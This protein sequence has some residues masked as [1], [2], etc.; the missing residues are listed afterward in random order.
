MAVR[1]AATAAAAIVAAGMMDARAATILPT[2]TPG[3]PT[4]CAGKMTQT[5]TDPANCGACG[6]DC[7][8]AACVGALCRS[9]L[10]VADKDITSIAVD[11][12]D[13]LWT[14][15]KGVFNAPAST[16]SPVTGVVT[17]SKAFALVR[18]GSSL[19]WRQADGSV[20]T[21]TSGATPKNLV[22]ATAPGTTNEA[23]GL[24]VD[25]G[26]VYWAQNDTIW[27][28]PATGGAPSMFLTQT[29]TV[30][31]GSGGG[32]VV[33]VFPMRS[34]VVEAG[35][36]DWLQDYVRRFSLVTATAGNKFAGYRGE[37]GVHQPCAPTAA[38]IDGAFVYLTLPGRVARVPLAG[39]DE[40][41]LADSSTGVAIAVDASYVYFADASGIERV[42]K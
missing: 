11:A 33:Q 21:M 24:A 17:K 38:A 22:P 14:T 41:I 42:A 34:L 35:E 1:R 19:Y 30:T 37:C 36:I 16:G 28:V 10:V 26:S 40:T 20:W 39:G 25:G 6:H 5:W 3:A 12:V 13:V 23:G 31:N 8:G 18:D 29:V 4:S 27:K 2:P 7:L 32:K 15:P 9:A